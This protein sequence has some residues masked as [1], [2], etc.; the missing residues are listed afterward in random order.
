MVNHYPRGTT[1]RDIQKLYIAWKRFI[2][3]VDNELRYTKRMLKLLD[4]INRSR[5]ERKW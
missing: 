2:L 3:A 1:Q 4:F 5:H